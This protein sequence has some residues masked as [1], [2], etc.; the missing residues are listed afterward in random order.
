VVVNLSGAPRICTDVITC[1]S[2]TNESCQKAATRPGHAANLGQT[3]KDN[4]WTSVAATEGDQFYALPVEA[5]G[6]IGESALALARRLAGA[7]GAGDSQDTR[8]FETYVTQQ[9]H[10]VNKKGVAKVI[11]ARA[12]SR[13][14]LGAVPRRIVMPLCP[15][16]AQPAGAPIRTTSGHLTPLPTWTQSLPPPPLLTVPRAG[17]ATAFPLPVGDIAHP[18]ADG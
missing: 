16:P 8:A 3:A 5:G 17:S 12:T 18:N 7:S 2:T 4:K 11:L 1:D 9:I 15:P 6:R 10:L 13:E 14:A